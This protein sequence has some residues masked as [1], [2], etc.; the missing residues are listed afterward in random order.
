[1]QFLIILYS[2]ST[3]I[4][5]CYIRSKCSIENDVHELTDE[6]KL[7]ADFFKK[8][9]SKFSSYSIQLKDEIQTKANTDIKPNTDNIT[10]SSVLL[11]TQ[12]SKLKEY[13]QTNRHYYT[14]WIL[15]RD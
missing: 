14:S 7:W 3:K 13:S 1:M 12:I 6:I 11:S 2:S 15:I 8:N 10:P 9:K 4:L 5:Y